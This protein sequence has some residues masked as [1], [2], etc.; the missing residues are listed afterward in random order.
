MASKFSRTGFFQI[1]CFIDSN[2]LDGSF[3]GS[4]DGNLKRNAAMRTGT[5][6]TDL[7]IARTFPLGERLKLEG[8]AE[9]GI[10][11]RTGLEP[12]AATARYCQT[13][14]LDFTWKTPPSSA[15]RKYVPSGMR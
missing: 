11:P 4:L 15:W 6:V 12:Y 10:A 14:P 9:E 2:P 5:I 13:L 3:T 8:I 1:P 7:R